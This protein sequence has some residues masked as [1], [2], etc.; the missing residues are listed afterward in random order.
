MARIIFL[1][2][3]LLVLVYFV[4]RYKRLSKEEKNQAIKIILFTAAG[5]LLV[6]L[7]LTGRLH[8]LVAA[9]GALIPLIPRFVRFIMSFGPT[10]LPYFRRYQQNRHSSMQSKM[11]RLQVN[12]ITGELQGEVLMGRFQG[13]KLQKMPVESLLELLA[14]CRTEDAESAALLSAY[15]DRAHAGWSAGGERSS[16]YTPHASDMTVQEAREILGVSDDATKEEIISAHK[17]M[18]QKLHPD[19]GGSDYLAKLVNLAKD[20]LLALL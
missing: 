15:L 1:L 19:R 13:Q 12:M 16:D 2:I 5:A 7:V 9:I 18:M 6:Y 10:L 14:E 8:A 11:L 4:Y 17:R 3:I 20:K